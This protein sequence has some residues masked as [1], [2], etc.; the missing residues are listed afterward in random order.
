MATF[1]SLA[2]TVTT[3]NNI[4]KEMLKGLRRGKCIVQFVRH[5]PILCLKAYTCKHKTFSFA[6]YLYS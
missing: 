5:P 3:H 6:R 1:E 2:M 4:H